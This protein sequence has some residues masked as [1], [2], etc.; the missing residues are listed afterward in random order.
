MRRWER[1]ERNVNNEVVGGEGKADKKFQGDLGEA[2]VWCG[3]W[4][5]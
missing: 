2:W 5:I 1:K 3:Q 4:C